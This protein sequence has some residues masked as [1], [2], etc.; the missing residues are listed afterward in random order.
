MSSGEIVGNQSV[1][2]KMVHEDASGN[3]KVLSGSIPHVVT[4]KPTPNPD[5]VFI[6]D[7]AFGHDGIP[8]ADIGRKH[9]K[10][11]YF[12]VTVRFETNALAIAELNSALKA[13]GKGTDV[14]LFVRAI[15]RPPA[16][17]NPAIPPAEVQVDW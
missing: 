2:W 3:K 9:G 13:I 12:K 8:Y 16:N 4:G 17:V 11:G 7:E 1:Y 15:D 6:S 10:R 5:V 14:E